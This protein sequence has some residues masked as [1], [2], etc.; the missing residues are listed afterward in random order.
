MM[1]CFWIEQRW[2]WEPRLSTDFESKIYHS[3]DIRWLCFGVQWTRD[4]K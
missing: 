4:V 2:S 3:I 1:L